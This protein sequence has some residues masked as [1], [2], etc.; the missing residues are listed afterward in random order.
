MIY[1]PYDDIIRPPFPRPYPPI[2]YA[3]ENSDYSYEYA[4]EDY[5]SNIWNPNPGPFPMP[6]PKPYP[7]PFPKPFP[8]PIV[9]AQEDA[10]EY[11]SN[12]YSYEY[13]LE[14]YESNI[15]PPPIK[16]PYIPRLPIRHP[17][18]P[19]PRF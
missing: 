16:P 18:I 4:L 13:V 15:I 1:R 10:H 8:G 9:W 2:L 12:D 14:D 6:Y 17:Y 3:K 5:E 19:R 11:Q 7:G